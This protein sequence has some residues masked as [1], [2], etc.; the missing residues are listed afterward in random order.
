MMS[1]TAVD[2]SGESAIKPPSSGSEM[3]LAAALARAGG[4]DPTALRMPRG[5][6]TNAQSAQPCPALLVRTCIGLTVH[7]N[8]S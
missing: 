7:V 1:G 2:H 3:V 5:N 4:I 8:T 6:T